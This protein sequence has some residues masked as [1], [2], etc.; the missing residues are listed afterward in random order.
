[1]R[2]LIAT[3]IVGAGLSLPCAAGLFS[4]GCERC[5]CQQSKKVCRVVPDVKKV[6]ETK[7]V[8]ECEEICL[9]GKSRCTE[10]MVEDQCVAGS[11]RCETVRE[12]TCD[13]IVTKK[14]LKKVTTTV[15]KPGWKCVVET[16]CSQCGNQCGPSHCGK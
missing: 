3:L 14:T 7:F 12:P 4:H 9:P 13:R 15:D 8:V 6:T 10:R 2:V 16:V 1:M 11:Q 5:G